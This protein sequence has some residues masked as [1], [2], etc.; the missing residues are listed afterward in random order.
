MKAIL[1]IACILFT[2]TSSSVFSAILYR[3]LDMK[4]NAITNA[5]TPVFEISSA[6]QVATKEYVD[7]LSDETS[8]QFTTLTN[9]LS[10]NGVAGPTGLT[11]ATGATGNQGPEGATG[12]TGSTGATG[13]QGIEGATGVQGEQGD[14]GPTGATGSQ[15]PQGEQ[16]DQGPQ[17][18][19][20]SNGAVGATGPTGLTGATGHTGATGATGAFENGISDV[21]NV[22]L[23][24]ENMHARMTF[25][26]GG[27]SDLLKY[28]ILGLPRKPSNDSSEH[29]VSWPNP[30]FTDQGNGTVIDNLTGLMWTKNGDPFGINFGG[31]DWTNALRLCNNYVYAGHSDWRLPN[32]KELESLVKYIYLSSSYWYEYLEVYFNN[33]SHFAYWSSTSDLNNPSSRVYRLYMSRGT[34]SYGS[35]PSGQNA[36]WV[37]RSTTTT[38]ICQPHKTDQTTVYKTGDNGTYQTGLTLPSGSERFIATSSDGLE[39]NILDSVTGLVWT[40]DAN[41][42]NVAANWATATNFCAQL[43]YGGFSDWRLPNITELYSLVDYGN[44]NPV[45]PSGH[46]FINIQTAGYSNYWTTSKIYYSG[47]RR[48]VTELQRGHTGY[49][50]T[51]HADYIW[52]VRGGI[53]K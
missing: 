5:E 41:L 24:E 11:G 6:Q 3:P 27:L 2:I 22:K 1:T 38:P 20:G 16:G 40:K 29:G 51:N 15:G 18:V 35:W 32:I 42:N 52:P 34:V 10:I 37:V 12:A 13:P 43:E 26:D 17:G 46:P 25:T 30:R 23:S 44:N 7:N 4:G 8:L 53:D 47:E 48:L 33:V 14:T 9:T 45:L 19:P 36:V 21:V 49:M 50:P 39:S 31:T 28:N